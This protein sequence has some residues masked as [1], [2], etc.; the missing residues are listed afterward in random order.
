VLQPAQSHALTSGS[1]AYF[2]TVPGGAG[3]P[4]PAAAGKELLRLQREHYDAQTQN[5]TPV[6]APK[7][8][9]ETL[10]GARGLR[11]SLW[12]VP[13]ISSSGIVAGLQARSRVLFAPD[14]RSYLAPFPLPASSGVYRQPVPAAP[15][16][17]EAAAAW[18]SDPLLGAKRP[19][20]VDP[21]PAAPVAGERGGSRRLYEVLP[22]LA[23][24]YGVDI[25]ADAYRA[26]RIPPQ[27]PRSG[28]VLALYEALNRYV[29]PS[30]HWSKDGSFLRV[31]SH[32]W[33][34]DRLSDIPDRLAREWAA[35]LRERH[36]LTLD[37]AA[38]LV[39]RLRDE[40][41]PE[42]GPR[43]REEG[44][45][46]GASDLAPIVAPS[47]GGG[48]EILRAYGRLTERQQQVLRAGGE[49]AWAGLPV[50]ARQ[51][52]Q[53]A[54][55]HQ[56][57]TGSSR[58][59][60]D[61]PGAL[62]LGLSRLERTVVSADVE[63]IRFRYRGLDGSTSG[64]NGVA[65]R[66]AAPPGFDQGGQILQEVAFRYR[67]GEDQAAQFRLQLPWAYLEPAAKAEAPRAG[68][69]TAR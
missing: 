28:Q 64:G 22:E 3:A 50:P 26:Q 33:Y 27:P 20:Q 55:E 46:L 58:S 52:L 51:W 24:T 60:P 10:A 12:L 66:S 61:A 40:Q 57:R 67:C 17:E 1:T 32:T 65:T 35:R 6:S 11:V 37:D 30:G 62:S 41:L 49:V 39:T 38:R 7:G 15:S 36:Q 18:G 44:V 42:F 25:I 19:F 14:D 68:A 48:K 9:A 43:M 63:S 31:R 56:E 45:H 23:E 16:A 21:L 5:G 2:S 29:L 34:F 53:T 8:L 69:G 59:L 47:G 13:Q 54:I 4:L